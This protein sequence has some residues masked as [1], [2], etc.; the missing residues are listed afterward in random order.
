MC[1]DI[2]QPS[3]PD[4]PPANVHARGFQCSISLLPPSPPPNQPQKT[5]DPATASAVS[6]M[7]KQRVAAWVEKHLV[8]LQPALSHDPKRLEAGFRS[9]S[10]ER[11]KSATVR[12]MVLATGWGG[13]LGSV[14]LGRGQ[15]IEAARFRSLAG[16]SLAQ[17][18]GR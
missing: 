11:M 16:R 6:A 8:L 5:P 7:A 2:R 4:P 17:R 9:I 14:G 3:P 15:H 18:S 13:G 10:R 12:E 1:T